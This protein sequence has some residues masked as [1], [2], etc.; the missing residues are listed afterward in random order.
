MNAIVDNLNDNELRNCL[1]EKQML[2]SF[3]SK[4]ESSW[5]IYLPSFW[6]WFKR[7]RVVEDPSCHGQV[8]QDPTAI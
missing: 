1:I 5:M 2:G 7:E 3:F 8:M 6:E 4:K